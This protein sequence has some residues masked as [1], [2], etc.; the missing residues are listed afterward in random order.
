M[1]EELPP[2]PKEQCSQCGQSLGGAPKAGEMPDPV[3]QL[4]IRETVSMPKPEVTVTGPGYSVDYSEGRGQI[5]QAKKRRLGKNLRP[6]QSKI[7]P[8]VV[9]AVSTVNCKNA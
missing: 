7:F 3:G 1:I 9:E 6:L 2:S 5:L 4:S 8:E